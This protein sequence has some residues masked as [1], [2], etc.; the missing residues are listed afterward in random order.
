MTWKS[1]FNSWMKYKSYKLV[2]FTVL[3]LKYIF[4]EFNERTWRIVPA[5]KSVVYLAKFNDVWTFSWVKFSTNPYSYTVYCTSLCVLLLF[6]VTRFVSTTY[7]AAKMARV[8]KWALTKQVPDT[9]QWFCQ[10]P[11]LV[12]LTIRQGPE[13]ILLPSSY[14]D[15]DVKK[16]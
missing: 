15:W 13:E 5:D 4:I 3:S 2:C 6:L 1:N 8:A 7:V 12:L 16:Q 10:H 11:S 9:A 14:T